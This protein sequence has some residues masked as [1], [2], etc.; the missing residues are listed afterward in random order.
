MNGNGHEQQV[1]TRSLGSGMLCVQG[2]RQADGQVAE[3]V[4]VEQYWISCKEELPLGSAG[5][6]FSAGLVSRSG[7][8][9]PRD[10]PRSLFENLEK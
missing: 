8:G 3:D 7:D 9:G 6:W 1:C 2:C 4:E 5:S 10:D